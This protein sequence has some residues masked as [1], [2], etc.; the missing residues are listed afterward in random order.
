MGTPTAPKP[1]AAP[2]QQA[3]PPAQAA[4]QQRQPQPTSAPA[5]SSNS[6]SS[7]TT[8]LAGAAAA[9]WP[10]GF[11]RW[12]EAEATKVLGAGSGGAPPDLTLL[13]FLLTLDSPSETAEYISMYFGN[14]AATSKFAAAF[15]NKK[16]EAKRKSGL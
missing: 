10:I 14:S 4:P 5:S 2:A 1:Q 16:A 3:K 12:C 7:A 9:G 6:A 15:I 13:E 8:Q 11:L